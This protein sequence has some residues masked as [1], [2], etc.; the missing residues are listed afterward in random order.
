[1]LVSP[2]IRRVEPMRL[3]SFP[4]EKQEEKIQIVRIGRAPEIIAMEG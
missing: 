2:E 1:M 4:T 3:F